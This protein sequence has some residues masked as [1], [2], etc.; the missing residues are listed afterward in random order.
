MTKIVCF[1]WG[2]FGSQSSQRLC[3]FFCWLLTVIEALALYVVVGSGETGVVE[4]I[5]HAFPPQW[6]C[7]SIRVVPDGSK[8]VNRKISRVGAADTGVKA[9]MGIEQSIDDLLA[10]PP[11]SQVP[12]L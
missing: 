4:R 6:T 1:G 11:Y 12:E 10:I 5:R 2:C 9:S 7:A 3:D 8:T